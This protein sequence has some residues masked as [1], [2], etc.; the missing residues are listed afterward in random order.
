MPTHYDVGAVVEAAVDIDVDGVLTDPSALTVKYRDPGGNVT[1]KVFGTD[2][3]VVNDDVGIYHI[4]IHTDEKGEWAVRWVGTGEASGATEY[5][6]HVRA[7]R[8][9]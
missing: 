3:E 2:A 6:F 4:D 1:T 7:S 5:S 8:F 9:P